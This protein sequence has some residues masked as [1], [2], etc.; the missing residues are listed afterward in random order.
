LLIGLIGACAQRQVQL[1]PAPLTPDCPPCP[2]E[3]ITGLVT[4]NQ[5]LRDRLAS[6]ETR[7]EE[8]EAMAARQEIRMLQKEA[9]AN[10]LQRRVLSQQ[11]P[12]DD[13]ITEVVRTRAKLRSIESRAEAASTIAETEIAVKTMKIRLADTDVEG[14]AAGGT[15]LRSIDNQA[16]LSGEVFLDQ[17]LPLTLTKSTNLREGPEITFRILATLE[18]DSAVVGYSHMG[19]WIRI[20]TEEGLT[21][22]VYLSLVMVR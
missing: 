22:W 21:G 19:N 13:A 3:K 8:L 11:K 12:L 5:G 20:D 4:Q 15:I 2:S 7:I 16:P 10:E 9:L 18:K 6:R 1:P 17:P 14:A